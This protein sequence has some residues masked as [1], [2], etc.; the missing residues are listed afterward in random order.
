MVGGWR[1][2]LRW[3]GCC[4]NPAEVLGES[5]PQTPSLRDKTRPSDSLG[6]RCEWGGRG[7]FAL[8]SA[9]GVSVGWGDADLEQNLWEHLW[10]QNIE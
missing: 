8:L 4:W 9:R 1:G 2:V 5:L 7:R 3:V 10:E 6:R